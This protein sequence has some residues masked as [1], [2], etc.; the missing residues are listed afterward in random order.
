MSVFISGTAISQSQA[1]IEEEKKSSG[2][3]EQSVTIY[4]DVS[5][6]RIWYMWTN[7]EGWADW[8]DHITKARLYG[9]YDE[10]V[11]GE[12]QTTY[13]KK[14]TKIMIY[15]SDYLKGY[16]D[17]SFLPF[18]VKWDVVHKMVQTENGLK[19]CHTVKL[20]GKFSFL[21][22][23][24]AREMVKGLPEAMDRMI[25]MAKEKDNKSLPR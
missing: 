12:M 5:K 14:P 7:V 3:W 1:Q 15:Q 21:F 24:T 23:K 6:E 19:L 13:S 17:R 9:K 25:T 8:K 4:T 2:S 22:R 16:T 10:G 20:R 11:K 18:G